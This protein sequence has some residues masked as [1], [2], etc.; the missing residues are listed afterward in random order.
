MPPNGSQ[1]Q[2]ASR[3][4]SAVQAG[5]PDLIQFLADELE[6][7]KSLKRTF[8]KSSDQ[9]ET[10][11]AYLASQGTPSPERLPSPLDSKPSLGCFTLDYNGVKLG[12]ICFKDER[13]IH[14]I[15]AHKSD[16]ADRIG[17]A[18]SVYELDG[19]AFKVWIEGDKIY[20]I[21]MEGR[22]EMLPEFI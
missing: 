8:A 21:S 16:C 20:I 10:L 4:S 1:T 13:V 7:I 17:K 22:K 11:Q 18:P 15:T 5:I 3:D 19:Q 2:V 14:L 9:P 12:M 6:D